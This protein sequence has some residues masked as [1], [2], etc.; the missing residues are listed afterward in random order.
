MT[1]MTA[2]ELIA[3]SIEEN[4]TVT[5]YPETKEEYESLLDDLLS[6][7]DDDVDTAEHSG[8]GH[9]GPESRGWTEIWSA[10]GWRVDLVHAS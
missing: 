7:S 1:T 9:S 3:L 5:E 10:D 6:S 4:R 2:S 8:S